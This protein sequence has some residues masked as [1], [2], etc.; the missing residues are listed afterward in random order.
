[1]PVA[2]A[3]ASLKD[4]RLRKSAEFQD[5][6]AKGAKK[7]SRSF[8]VFALENGLNHSRFGLTTPRKLGKA[9]DRNRAKR[10]IR[11][12][13]RTSLPAIP[14]GFDFV[15]NP[16]RSAIDRQFEE[17]RVELIGLLGTEK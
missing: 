14:I 17:L 13:L 7:T 12:I 10:R 3:S 6:Y 4:F 1:V 15:V 16:R 2:K 8:V 9:H 11:E 5:V